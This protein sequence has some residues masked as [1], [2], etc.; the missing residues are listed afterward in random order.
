[1]AFTVRMQFL[2][3]DLSLSFAKFIKD[4]P[5]G[6]Y[7]KI[8]YLP[9]SFKASWMSS[10]TFCKANDLQMLT[11]QTHDEQSKFI[12][13]VEA[14]R[15]L[16]ERMFYTTEFEFYLGAFAFHPN[17]SLEFVW[18]QDGKKIYPNLTLAWNKGEPNDWQ[19]REWCSSIKQ[20]YYDNEKQIGVNDCDCNTM[21]ITPGTMICQNF[22][23]I[24]KKG[25][26]KNKN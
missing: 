24:K 10:F 13:R 14:N 7:K 15:D 19:G 23:V 11:F 9:T 3:L 26:Y 2:H 18:Y 16:F 12:A 4:D 17:R 20:G 22:E 5:D 6:V 21:D 8:Y 25:G 1:M